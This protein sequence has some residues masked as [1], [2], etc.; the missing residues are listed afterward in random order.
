MELENPVEDDK[1]YVYDKAAIVDYLRKE[2]R[3]G[4]DATC[5]VAGDRVLPG[6]AAWLH[7]VA[8]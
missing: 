8:V 2:R 1:G 7:A 4:R 6:L 3:Q 5:P